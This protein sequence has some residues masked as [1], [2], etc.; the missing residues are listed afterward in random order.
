MITAL[1]TQAIGAIRPLAPLEWVKSAAWPNNPC[2]SSR[3]AL[4]VYD[5]FSGIGAMTLG[6]WEAA[7]INGLALRVEIAAEIEPALIDCYRANFGHISQQLFCGDVRS[8]TLTHTTN[9]PALLLAGPPCQGH[10]SLNNRS[11]RRDER[12][13]LYLEIPRL[14]AI[15]RPDAVLIENVDGVQHDEH[16][17][18]RRT[19]DQLGAQGYNCVTLTVRADEFGLAQRRRRFILVATKGEFD[20]GPLL[21]RRAGSTTLRHAIGDI[22]S[23]YLASK[24]VFRTASRMLPVNKTRADYLYDQDKFELPDSLRP[25]CH[26]S[27]SHTYKTVYGRLHWDQPAQTITSGFG[28]MGQ[29]RFLHPSRRRTITPHEA[30]RIQGLPDFFDLSRILHRSAL[31]RAIANAVPPQI[32]GTIVDELLR[33]GLLGIKPISVPST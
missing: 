5:I 9:R 4:T 10:S 31:Q 18:V 19:V 21:A 23:E 33:Q 1:A 28:C 17:V 6:A 30:A 29:G 12:N 27:G 13:L 7:R 25:T 11:R 24:D 16:E 26:Q 8:L 22:E 20:S 14:V 32:T 2:S 3:P 15:V